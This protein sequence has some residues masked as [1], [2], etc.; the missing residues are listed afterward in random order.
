MSSIVAS[1]KSNVSIER[2]W[3]M[4]DYSLFLILIVTSIFLLTVGLVYVFSNW[5][6][7][8][9]TVTYGNKI[10]C[11]PVEN[12]NSM[13][14]CSFTVRYKVIGEDGTLQIYFV[15]VDHVIGPNIKPGDIVYIQYDPKNPASVIYG[16]TSYRTFGLL[17]LSVGALL[18][19]I[20]IYYWSN[21]KS[22]YHNRAK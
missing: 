18:T 14:D 10:D 5:V 4:L 13:Y 22:R 6:L 8:T 12:T 2:G 3:L 7:T 9:G 19:L 15:K 1:K 16:N 17:Y 21:I 11:V 20:S